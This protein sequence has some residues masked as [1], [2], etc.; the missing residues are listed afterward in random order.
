MVAPN[1][2][3]DPLAAMLAN[4]S[5][6]L[7]TDPPFPGRDDYSAGENVQ[8]DLVERRRQ[9]EQLVGLNGSEHFY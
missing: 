3:L 7:E 5:R 9:A 8:R 4:A 6:E 1:I 2:A